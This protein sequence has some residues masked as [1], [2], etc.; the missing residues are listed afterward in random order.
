MRALVL[1]AVLLGFAGA[2]PAGADSA[3]Y[4]RGITLFVLAAIYAAVLWPAFR[5]HPEQH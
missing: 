3:E 2:V 4:V 5:A 1:L